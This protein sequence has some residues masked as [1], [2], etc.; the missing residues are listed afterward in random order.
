MTIQGKPDEIAALVFALQR[1]QMKSGST[2]L[3]DSMR[4][5]LLEQTKNTQWK[6]QLKND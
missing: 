3:A 6:D 2:D 4:D 5:I 1:R